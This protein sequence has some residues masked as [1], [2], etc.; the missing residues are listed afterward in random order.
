MTSTLACDSD[1]GAALMCR[2]RAGD[3]RA[4][5]E[6]VDRYWPRVL[7]RFVRRLRDRHEAEDLTQDVFLRVYRSRHRYEASAR[8]TTWL[9][10]I[11]DNVAR[12]ALR[13]RRRKPAT[14]VGD[15][16]P[17]S[18]DGPGRTL[19]DLAAPGDAV[20]RKESAG[21]VRRAIARLDGRHRE[22]LELQCRHQS[23]EEIA[24][25]LRITGRA[26]KSLLYRARQQLRAELAGTA[27]VW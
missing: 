2:V 3:E 19:L 22:A 4:Y 23:H 18:G 24:R 17:E 27:G 6:L 15:F 26:T 10:H 21:V 8:F 5:R 13:T 12:N 1:E 9:F 16:F 11:A 25:S 20:E 14:P 7:G